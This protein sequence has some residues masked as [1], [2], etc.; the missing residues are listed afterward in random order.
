MVA[1]LCPTI[2]LAWKRWWRPLPS[3]SSFSNLKEP[4]YKPTTTAGLLGDGM[5]VWGV[6]LLKFLR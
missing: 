3:P 1:P 5:V 6:F 2:Y 4:W